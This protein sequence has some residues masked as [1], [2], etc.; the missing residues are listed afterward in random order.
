MAGASRLSGHGF[1]GK[2]VPIPNS[3]VLRGRQLRRPTLADGVY[4]FESQADR[5]GRA[6]REGTLQHSEG[7]ETFALSRNEA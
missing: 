6:G 7:C 3:F 1:A 4:D 5:R 2:S